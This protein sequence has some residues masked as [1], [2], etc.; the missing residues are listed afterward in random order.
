MTATHWRKM[1][2]PEYYGSHDL[3]NPDGTFREITVTIDKVSSKE[4]AGDGGKKS[5]KNILH[6]KETKPIILNNVN[7]RVI[8]W[9]AGTPF[10]EKWAGHRITIYVEKVK[11]FGETT[12][13]LRVRK[14]KPG[15]VKQVD[16]TSE[17]QQIAECTT[18]EQLGTLWMTFPGET[19]TALLS[20]K[21]KRKTELT[22]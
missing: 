9:V 7:Q 17:I 6:T 5:Q 22:V 12:D 10:V 1:A 21:D 16:Y 11:A 3:I 14:T 20:Y 8:S 18:L 4:I 2:N 15:A 19:K 13:A